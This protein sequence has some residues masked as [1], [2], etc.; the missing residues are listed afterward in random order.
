MA[1]F[2]MDWAPGQI[3]AFCQ[4]AEAFLKIGGPSQVQA[5]EEDFRKLFGNPEVLQDI[6]NTFLKR[7]LSGEANEG[8]AVLGNDNLVIT[9]SAD[10]TVRI[11]KERSDVFAFGQKPTSDIITNYPS[12]TL[13]L[14]HCEEPIDVDWYCR[15]EGADF[16]RY[17][18]TLK[19]CR[20]ATQTCTNGD[21]LYVDAKNRFP[22]LPARSRDTFVVLSGAAVNAQIVSFDRGTLG[23][24]GASMSAETSS[25]L[26]VMLDLVQPGQPDYP[27]NAVLG[28]TAHPDHHVRWSAVTALGKHDRAA[29][30][31]VIT[32]LAG[33]DPHPFIRDAA[34]RTLQRCEEAI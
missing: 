5:L 26:C 10:L 16:D 13:I 20:E 11:L 3:Q 12:N 2:S 9:Y 15:A 4:A 19:I 14:I 25:V 31:N 6:G 30:L 28:L 7:V 29:A 27:V 34:R 18:A 21:V 33:N 24:V 1:R 32:G 17:D 23:P 8:D 22:V